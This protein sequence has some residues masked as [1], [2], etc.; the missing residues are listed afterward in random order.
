ME[1]LLIMK[2]V[3]IIAAILFL[4][5][6]TIAILWKMRADKS[7]DRIRIALRSRE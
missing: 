1:L 4:G 2:L 7:K 5:N 6:I 3:H